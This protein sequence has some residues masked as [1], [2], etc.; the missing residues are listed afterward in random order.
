[1]TDADSELAWMS[2]KQSCR[3]ADPSRVV[4]DHA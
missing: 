4:T 2:I 3:A 1:M